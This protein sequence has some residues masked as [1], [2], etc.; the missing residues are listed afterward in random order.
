MMKRRD[1][2]RW[3]R[4]TLDRDG[5]EHGQCVTR[6]QSGPVWQSYRKGDTEVGIR[7]AIC[8]G[9]QMAGRAAVEGSSQSRGPLILPHFSIGAKRRT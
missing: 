7:E 6:A 2:R 1:L 8:G 5:I 3:S 4:L 9:E